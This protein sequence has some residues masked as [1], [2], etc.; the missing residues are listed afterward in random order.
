[1]LDTTLGDTVC[2]CLATDWCFSP[3]TPVFSTNKTDLH[4]ITEILLKVALNNI[5]LTKAKL[6][7]LAHVSYTGTVF[8]VRF[9]H[10]SSLL[11]VLFTQVSLYIKNH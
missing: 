1:V 11:R 5:V 2:Q 9:I 8:K 4:E 3:G 6:V 7:K 10:E